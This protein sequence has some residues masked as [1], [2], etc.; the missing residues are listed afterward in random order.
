MNLQLLITYISFIVL[1]TTNDTL[2]NKYNAILAKAIDM[3]KNLNKTNTLS[4]LSTLYVELNTFLLEN[5]KLL[6]R[7]ERSYI[8]A[9]KNLILQLKRYLKVQLAKEFPNIILNLGEKEFKLGVEELSKRK[10]ISKEIIL[11]NKPYK[12]E[13]KVLQPSKKGKNTFNKKK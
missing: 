10:R 1:L 7:K 11:L 6:S 13:Y 3:P 2:K 4:Y 12:F 9:L 5:V 8:K